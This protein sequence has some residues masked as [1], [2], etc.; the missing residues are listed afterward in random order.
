MSVTLY[1]K[2]LSL[3]LDV[4]YQDHEDLINGL[5]EIYPSASSVTIWDEHDEY[6]YD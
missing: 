2:R 3:N 5:R 4:D 1:F 6:F